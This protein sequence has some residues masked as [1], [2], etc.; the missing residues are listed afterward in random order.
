MSDLPGPEK[1]IDWGQL[2]ALESRPTTSSKMAHPTKRL[3]PRHRIAI[4]L[5]E[6]GW[7]NK[8]IAKALGYTEARISLILNSPHAGLQ[9]LRASFASQVADVA[10]D[11]HS[12]LRL[13]ANEML[14]IMVRHARNTDKGESS[15]L[16]ARDILHMAGFSP[17]KRELRMNANVP[18]EQLQKVV[19]KLEEANEVAHA[20]ADQWAV[21]NP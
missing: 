6:S 20:V 2:I 7:K 18:V 12:R 4:M 9:E 13:Y 3:R 8:D 17:V 5:H 16:A 1:P 19:E 11:T 21:K 10:L 15:R 14:D